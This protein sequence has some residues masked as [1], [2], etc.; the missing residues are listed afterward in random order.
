M[1]EFVRIAVILLL[2]INAPAV[3]GRLPQAVLKASVGRRAALLGLA[4]VIVT[5]VT[6]LL[7]AINEPLLDGLE[8]EPETFRVSAGLV[9]LLGG[10]RLLLAPRR[11]A[12]SAPGWFAAVIPLAFPLL[13]TPEMAALTVSYAADDGVSRTIGAL[14]VATVAS[15]ALATVLSGRNDAWHT[16][17]ISGTARFAGAIVAVAGV[18]LIVDGVRAI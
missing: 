8:V 5:G 10:A 12:A 2:A 13:L 7:A 4:F 6:A 9:A 1:S 3:A 11:R 18:G 15:W 14:V 16:T 17:L